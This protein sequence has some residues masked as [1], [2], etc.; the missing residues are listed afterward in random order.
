MLEIEKAG[1]SYAAH[2]ALRDVNLAV[3]EGELLSIAGPS[4][5][6]APSATAL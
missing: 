6:G 2:T 1:H 3:T 4:A 5:S